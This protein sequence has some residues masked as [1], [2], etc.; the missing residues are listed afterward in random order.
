MITGRAVP[1]ANEC[2][3]LGSIL[4]AGVSQDDR[5]RCFAYAEAICELLRLDNGVFDL[6]IMLTAEGPVLVEA[7]PR[8]MGGVMPVAYNLTTGE[9]FEDIVIEIHTGRPIRESVPPQQYS[10]IRKLIAHAN[11]VLGPCTNVNSLATHRDCAYFSNDLIVGG[12]TITHQD[13]LGR[14]IVCD[15]DLDRAVAKAEKL[16]DMFEQ[17]LGISLLHPITR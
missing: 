6:E 1:E 16:L 13:I 7:N 4:P 5:E 11:A 2:C 9:Y 8:M 17:H 15:S 12:R 10:V 3:G 14:F